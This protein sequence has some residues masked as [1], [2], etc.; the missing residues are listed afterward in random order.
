[1]ALE[2]KK[3]RS[4]KPRRQK[5][6]PKEYEY[7]I[8]NKYGG[9]EVVSP[10]T[11]EKLV[12]EGMGD[13]SWDNLSMDDRYLAK[14]N[15]WGW[16]INTWEKGKR[17]Y[18]GILYRPTIREWLTHPG[19]YLALWGGFDTGKTYGACL[20]A[21][22]MAL[23]FPGSVTVLYRDTYPQLISTTLVTLERKLWADLGIREGKNYRH[24]AGDKHRYYEIKVGNKY[25]YIY[26]RSMP[27]KGIDL[28]KLVAGEKSFEPDRIIIEES[29]LLD[30]RFFWVTS[31]RI[32]RG[33]KW[34]PAW[35]RKFL[36]LGNP[37]PQ[38][39]WMYEVF[40]KKRYPQDQEEREEPLPDPHNYEQ[41]VTTAYDNRS[42]VTREELYGLETLPKSLRTMFLMG[43]AG[44]ELR[45]T[46]VFRGKF[47]EKL[48]AS[49]KRLAFYPD[50]PLLRGWDLDATGL[51][52]ACVICQIDASGQ[53]R[54]LKEVIRGRTSVG[55]FC[56]EV[57]DICKR[58]FKVRDD[59]ETV[60]VGDPAIDT[61]FNMKN[62]H[63]VRLSPKLLME[64]MGIL[65]HL[66]EKFLP[67]RLHVMDKLL[68]ELITGGE[69]KFMVDV[70]GCPVLYE[71]FKQRYVYE[72]NQKGVVAEPLKDDFAH[73]QDA[74]QYL[75]THMYEYPTRPG[76]KKRMQKAL[77]DLHKRLG[78]NQAPEPGYRY[79]FG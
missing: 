50:R 20:S 75:A 41:F 18:K 47:N 43:E 53:F 76:K 74:I 7:Y 57:L 63:G 24:R 3:V 22:Q 71:G 42:A 49:W 56:Q 52:M 15:G 30:Q 66:G 1:M 2:P 13:L 8:L 59:V 39:S 10:I 70:H 40:N 37:P 46:P 5:A 48:H 16:G 25:S 77:D 26:Y 51:V 31:R 45:G 6:Y 9:K 67:G 79:D 33:N 78:I 17:V 36:V 54:A 58:E 32:D 60:D 65:P 21:T 44:F 38:G 29:A 61:K 4:R 69:A 27:E 35:A 64:E 14:R 12:V 62:Q 72:T 68:K 55:D 73:P 28:N 19:R 23:S 11:G 34:I